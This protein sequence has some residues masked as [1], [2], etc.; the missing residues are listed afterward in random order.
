MP[1]VAR[2]ASA[3]TCPMPILAI[4]PDETRRDPR[5]IPVAAARR[6]DCG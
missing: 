3:I 1:I 2:A 6:V 5:D 4:G